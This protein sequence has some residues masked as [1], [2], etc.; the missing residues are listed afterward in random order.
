MFRAKAQK[1]VQPRQLRFLNCP[2][3]KRR[4]DV[5]WKWIKRRRIVTVFAA[6]V[7]VLPPTLAQADNG[8]AVGTYIISLGLSG[9]QTQSDRM[10][11]I[12]R[13]PSGV[14]WVD[15]QSYVTVQQAPGSTTLD[16]V[17][18]YTNLTW[19]AI[20]V[21]GK[22]NLLLSGLPPMTGIGSGMCGWTGNYGGLTFALGDEIS[23]DTNYLYGPLGDWYFVSSGPGHQALNLQWQTTMSTT[24]GGRMRGQLSYLSSDTALFAFFNPAAP[25]SVQRVK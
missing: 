21:L 10:T 9:A 19:G 12:F 2:I 18:M 20:A 17:T 5:I 15:R 4:P 7:I 24:S 13:N 11:A 22:F 6:A 14:T 25:A 23:L 1:R 16:I 8:S 3:T